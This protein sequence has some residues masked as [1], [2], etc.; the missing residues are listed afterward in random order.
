MEQMLGKNREILANPSKAFELEW[1]ETN[2]LGGWS[3]STVAGAH[4]RRYHGLLVAAIVPPAERTVLLSKLDETIIA[5]NNRYELGTNLYAGDTIYPRGHQYQTSFSKEFILEWIFELPGIKLRK[6]ICMVHGENTL[7]ISYE[8]LEADAA[9]EM[10]WTP[11]VAARTYHSLQHESPSLPWNVEFNNAIFHNCPVGDTDLFIHIPGARF[12]HDPKWYRQFEYTVEK[13]RGLDHQEDLLN[14][15]TFFRKLQQGDL[16]QVMVS[17]NDPAGKDSSAMLA[18]ELSRRQQLVSTCPAHSIKQQLLLAA[19]QFIVERS[20]IETDHGSLKT[21]IAGYHWFT[22][23]ARDTMISLPGL[24]LS[25]GRFDDARKILKAFANAV[26]QGMLPNRFQD[27]DEPPE[28]NNVDGTLWYFIAIHKYVLAT[29][30]VDFVLKE[31]LPV[32]K[33]IVDW[34]HRG[35]R[36]NIKVDTDGLLF[37]GEKGQQLTWMDARIGDWVVTPRMGKPV[38]IQALWYN[39]QLIFADLLAANGQSYDQQQVLASAEQ[40]KQSFNRLF[41]YAEK[42]Y[43]YDVIDEQGR[44]NQQVRPNQVFAIS[45]P[46]SILEKDKWHSV[47]QVVQRELFTPVGLRSLSGSDEQY[48]PQYKGDQWHRDSSYHQGTVWSWLLGPYIDAWQKTDASALDID[49]IAASMQD[50]LNQGCIGSVSEVF[51]GDVPHWPGG[52]AA[53][54]WGVAE[55]LRVIID[56]GHY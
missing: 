56:H 36:Y 23:W 14:H 43:L 48:C 35:T 3:S 11:L 34:H 50:H 12:H 52:C 41:W 39:A 20:G 1:L 2:G 27:N 31:L 16:L 51:D 29:G 25:T 33:E 26:S 45:L 40:T 42:N 7:I 53:Q 24:C 46:F 22:D 17:T 32:L 9:F 44:A 5:G 8:V 37:A 38:E 28:Y 10:Q 54:A 55:W 47:M 21:V 30:D 49:I 19:D 18:H 13:Q 6:S 15:G 4:T